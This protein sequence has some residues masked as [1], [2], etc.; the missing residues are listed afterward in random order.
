LTV[1]FV[2]HY[3]IFAPSEPFFSI[4]IGAVLSALGVECIHAMRQN[5]FPK[6]VSK[7]RSHDRRPTFQLDAA[8]AAGCIALPI[9]LVFDHPPPAGQPW[10]AF[11]LIWAIMGALTARMALRHAEG[12]LGTWI[13]WALL[14]VA[15]LESC[16]MVIALPLATLG[17]WRGICSLLVVFLLGHAI[18]LLGKVPAFGP[19]KDELANRFPAKDGLE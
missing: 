9:A 2:F 4:L 18:V 8:L 5:P 19:K 11:G 15:I 13:A 3:V 17:L 6:P 12:R 7:T 10:W 16:A 14:S 1:L